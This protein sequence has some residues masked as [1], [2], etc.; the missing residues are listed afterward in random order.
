MRKIII[1]GL[2]QRKNHNGI[3]KFIR[4]NKLISLLTLFL[5]CGMVLGAASARFANDN[6]IENMDFLFASNFKVRASQSLFNTFA[7]SL[8]S[9]F[10]FVICTFLMGL[11][12]WGVVPIPIIPLFR[13]VGLGLTAGFL[14]SNYGFKGFAYHLIVLLPGILISAAAI[15]LEAKE[16]IFFSLKLASTISPK[17]SPE[18][19]WTKFRMYLL[20]T[21]YVFII[22]VVAS[23]IDTLFTVLFAGWFNF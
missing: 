19:M 2:F 13:G 1:S 23:I 4:E 18:K 10:I 22:S 5:I 12:V 21:G 15:I 16:A 20:H 11:S 3:V 6:M 7:A 17:S 8:T 9:S 14:Y